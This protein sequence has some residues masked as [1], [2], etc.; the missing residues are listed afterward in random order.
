MKASSWRFRAL[1]LL[2]AD[3][4]GLGILWLLSRQRAGTTIP[5]YAAV[6]GAAE[7]EQVLAWGEW[8]Q[9]RRDP[10]TTAYANTGR[11][12][13][14]IGD[15]DGGFRPRSNVYDLYT[16]GAPQPGDPLAEELQGV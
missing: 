12:L 3:A 5:P 15:I 6:D 4:A 9:R 16:F 14:V 13:Y 7:V 8:I 11:Q 2:A 10:A 1:L